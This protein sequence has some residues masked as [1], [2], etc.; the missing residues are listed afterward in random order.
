MVSNFQRFQILNNKLRTIKVCA[1]GAGVLCIGALLGAIAGRRLFGIAMYGITA[2]DLIRISYNCYIKNYVCLAMSKLGGTTSGATE[3]F[4]A[5]M[6]SATGLTPAK[7]PF[8][9]IQ[10]EISYEILSK[11]T[12][13]KQLYIQVM[14]HT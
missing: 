10:N 14:I 3:S 7:D 11:N 4:F 2:A 1:F 8:N 6:S 5:W 13:C 12:I 9:I